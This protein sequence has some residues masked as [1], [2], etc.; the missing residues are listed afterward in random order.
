[1]AEKTPD[2]VYRESVGSLTLL[3]CTFTSTDIDNDDTYASGLGSNVFGY[4]FN[5]TLTDTAAKDV[6]VSESSGT[7]TFSTG[8]D[9]ITGHLYILAK[10]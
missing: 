7:F 9:D 5:N 3:K 10:V 4:W 6:H 8:E 2:S 1:M